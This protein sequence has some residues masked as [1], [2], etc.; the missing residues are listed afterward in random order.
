MK[1]RRIAGAIVVLLAFLMLPGTEVSAEASGNIS[2]RV[3]SGTVGEP[4]STELRVR[5]KGYQQTTELPS[6]ET[7]TSSDGYFEFLNVEAGAE[8][9][10][11]V[12]VEFGNIRYSSDIILLPADGRTTVSLEVFAATETNPGITFRTLTRLLRAQS[13]DVISV[14][15]IAEVYVPGD[16]SFTPSAQHMPPA[17][18]FAVPEHA[19]GLQPIGGFSRNDIV[20]GG[21]GFAI[22]GGLRPGI[23]TIIFGYQ[24]ALEGGSTTFEWSPTLPT[25]TIVLLVEKG[26]LKAQAPNLQPRG[27][28]SFGGTNVLRWQTDQVSTDTS[29]AIDVENTAVPGALRLFR[30]TTTD[31]WALGATIPAVIVGLGLIIWRRDWRTAKL[32]DPLAEANRLLMELHNIDMDPLNENKRHAIKTEL[33]TLLGKHPEIIGMLRRANARTSSRNKT[34]AP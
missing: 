15:Q 13:D 1:P 17:L 12:S 16:R 33:S 22:F 21:P 34:F 29:I 11:L 26:P 14:V 8:F 30:A 7:S 4:L 9:A 10:Y 27:E 2:G 25:D 32:L 19:F 31:R 28:S 20:I 6:R 24:L 23:N 18:R 3:I 5:L